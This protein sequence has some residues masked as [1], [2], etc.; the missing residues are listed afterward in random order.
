MRA[1]HPIGEVDSRPWSDE[2]ANCAAAIVDVEGDPTGQ[3]GRR[4][5]DGRR[6]LDE[7]AFGL[8]TDGT[9]G[10]DLRRRLAP[11]SQSRDVGR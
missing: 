4:A 9:G 7:L 5:D 3:G 11:V 2:H 1:A 8:L 10:G 6:E